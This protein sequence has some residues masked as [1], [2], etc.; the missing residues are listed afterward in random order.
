M[1]ER[2]SHLTVVVGASTI[3]EDL[4]RSLVRHGVDHAGV[5]THLRGLRKFMVAGDGGLVVLCIAL[6]QT[7]LSRHGEAL[8]L[9]LA[10]HHCFQ[11]EVRSVGL[12]AGIGLTSDVSQM[13][14]DVYVDDSKHAAKAVRVLARHWRS[15]QRKAAASERERSQSLQIETDGRN[16]WVWG[17]AQ[18]PI[19]LAPLVAPQPSEK[20]AS[21]K[22]GSSDS[23]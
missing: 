21:S 22:P 15:S 13:G 3:A 17:A 5:A 7:T 11:S 6:D 4:R 1:E 10:D 8:R 12:L 14:C 9:L 23:G 18:M 20:A 19:E 2:S 16:S